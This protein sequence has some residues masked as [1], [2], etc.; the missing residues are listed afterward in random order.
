MYH[1]SANAKCTPQS[2]VNMRAPNG[3]YN[4]FWGKNVCR[5]PCSSIWEQALCQ[6]IAGQVRFLCNNNKIFAFISIYICISDQPQWTIG[7]Q[8]QEAIVRLIEKVYWTDTIWKY[9]NYGYCYK[10]IVQPILLMER[11]ITDCGAIA[12]FSMLQTKKKN[13]K[14]IK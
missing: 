5:N 13:I 12:R 11:S 6:P 8:W 10:L 4:A 14:R 7:T 1:Q 3:P 9:V 2:I